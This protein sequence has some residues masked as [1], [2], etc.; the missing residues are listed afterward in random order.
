MSP[1]SIAPNGQ[2]Y[3]TFDLGCTAALITA[4]VELAGLNKSNPKKVQFIFTSE[5]GEAE[6]IVDDYFANRLQVHA[7]TYFDNLKMVKNRIYSDAAQ[8]HA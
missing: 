5:N 2:T 4:G 3:T 7:R 1:Q 6:Q 8:P